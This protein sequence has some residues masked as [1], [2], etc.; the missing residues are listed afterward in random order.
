MTSLRLLPNFESKRGN[1]V[2]KGAIRVAGVLHR[3][4][5]IEVCESEL[6]NQRALNG[7]YQELLA[8]V[9]QEAGFSS[10]NTI[11]IFGRPHVV[12]IMPIAKEEL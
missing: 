4:L 2:L 9:Y 8:T 5:A 6:G 3:V 11:R 12:L 1:S 7:E 10:L